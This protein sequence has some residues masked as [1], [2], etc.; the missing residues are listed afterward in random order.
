MSEVLH[1]I[2]FTYDRP[3]ENHI[4]AAHNHNPQT[5]QMGVPAVNPHAAQNIEV[6]VP[7]VNQQPANS[8]LEQKV[9]LIICMLPID[10]YLK[11]DKANIR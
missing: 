10:R 7:A 4:I 8:G 5:L 1:V 6:G 11:S 9:C 2:W 3:V